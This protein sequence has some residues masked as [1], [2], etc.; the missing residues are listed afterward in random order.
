MTDIEQMLLI[1]LAVMN[2]AGFF[3]MGIDKGR[4]RRHSW[5]IPEATLFLMAL[6]GGSVGVHAAM[7]VFRHKTRHISFV[8][9]IPAIFILQ[10]ALMIFLLYYSPVQIRFM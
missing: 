4:A 6:L 9:G 3:L 1:Y 2:V 8:V 10:V 5:R 7:Y